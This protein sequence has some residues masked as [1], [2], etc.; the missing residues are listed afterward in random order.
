M[1]GI[2]IGWLYGFARAIQI[3]GYYQGGHKIEG[4]IK[5]TYRAYSLVIQ[6]AMLL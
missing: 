4:K 3:I 6:P 1:N 2:V 5:N